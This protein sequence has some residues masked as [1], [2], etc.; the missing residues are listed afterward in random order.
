MYTGPRPREGGRVRFFCKSAAFAQVDVMVGSSGLLWVLVR[1]VAAQQHLVQAQLLAPGRKQRCVGGAGAGGA[2]LIGQQQVL[3]AMPHGMA[4]GRG[5]E[6]GGCVMGSVWR[7]GRGGGGCIQVLC[8]QVG[9]GAK[10]K[11]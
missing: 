1:A 10:T 11:L 6:G 4:G 8:C 7:I 3:L 2:M 9:K 5:L